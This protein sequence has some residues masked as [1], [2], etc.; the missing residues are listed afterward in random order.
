MSTSRY[1]PV[2]ADNRASTTSAYRSAWTGSKAFNAA[3]NTLKTDSRSVDLLA[4]AIVDRTASSG[5]SAASAGSVTAG[6]WRGPMASGVSTKFG[7]PTR[8]GVAH[9]FATLGD[10]VITSSTT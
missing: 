10:G 9:H 4:W 3:Q 2:A 8:I 1:F 6:I 7:S 5:F